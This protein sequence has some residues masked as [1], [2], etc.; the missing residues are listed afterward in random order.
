VKRKPKSQ[1]SALLAVVRE[2]IEDIDAVGTKALTDENDTNYWP[3]LA[4]T[5]RHAKA[6]VRKAKKG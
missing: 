6:A 1:K 2:F 4:I 3:D 5:Y